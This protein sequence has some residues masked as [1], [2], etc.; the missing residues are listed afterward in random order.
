MNA[1]ARRHH[2]V[3][4]AVGAIRAVRRRE[5]FRIL[6]ADILNVTGIRRIGQALTD[7]TGATIDAALTAVSREVE[8]APP[9]GIVAM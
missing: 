4:E 8:D 6:V 9:I 1:V 7:L 5:L 3:E 2:D